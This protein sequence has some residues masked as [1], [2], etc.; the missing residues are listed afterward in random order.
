M[1]NK[2]AINKVLDTPKNSDAK[3]LVRSIVFVLTLSLHSELTCPAPEVQM[4]IF[5]RDLLVESV[6]GWSM[7][8]IYYYWW[9][10]LW[11]SSSQEKFSVSLALD[12]DAGSSKIELLGQFSPGMHL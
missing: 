11:I 1:V 3:I 10:L 7:P 6:P 9:S 2:T 12:R 5:R 8:P 4:T